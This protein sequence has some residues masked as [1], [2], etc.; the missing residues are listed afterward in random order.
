VL[1]LSRKDSLGVLSL[2]ALSLDALSL[3]VPS[4]G[5]LSLDAL[6][7]CSHWMLSLDALTGCSHWMLSLD[8][9]TG[10]SRW[11]LSLDALSL[12]THSLAHSL[13]THPTSLDTFAW[14]LSLSTLAY[15]EASWSSQQCER[16]KLSQTC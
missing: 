10:C 14:T 13:W 6:T 16:Q 3:D 1:T 4:L 11:M 2:D 9:L 12:D 8:A 7:G 15:Y 5:A